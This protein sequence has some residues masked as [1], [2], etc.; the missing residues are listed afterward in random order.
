M[1]WD[2][3]EQFYL[4]WNDFIYPPQLMELHTVTWNRVS[5][6]P[7]R[8]V[9]RIELSLWYH[10]LGKK[11]LMTSEAFEKSSAVWCTTLF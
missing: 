11:Q 4:H 8:F 5:G 1:K 2:I 6:I 9:V 7:A 3:R 10:Q